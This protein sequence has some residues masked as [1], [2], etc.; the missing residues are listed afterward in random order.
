MPLYKTLDGDECMSYRWQEVLIVQPSKVSTRHSYESHCFCCNLGYIA[1][2]VSYMNW[3]SLR[4]PFCKECLEF[5]VVG[6]ISNTL[7][8]P[9]VHCSTCI[10]LHSLLLNLNIHYW[11]HTKRLSRSACN[12]SPSNFVLILRHIF[13]SSANI[14]ISLLINSGNSLT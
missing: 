2:V 5:L 3:Q 6:L 7:F 10:T 11:D 1:H 13:Q 12:T 4:G 14:F 9:Y 8:A